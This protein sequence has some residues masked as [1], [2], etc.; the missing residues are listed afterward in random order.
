MGTLQRFFLNVRCLQAFQILSKMSKEANVSNLFKISY[1]LADF[2]LMV[3]FACIFQL[4]T[5]QLCS[6]KPLHPGLSPAVFRGLHWSE[7]SEAAN[8]SCWRALLTDLKP[9]QRAMLY[10]AMQEVIALF[11]IWCITYL[12]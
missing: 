10:S 11:L 8:C 1:I 5:E 7:I 4:T 12:P 6:L 2:A 9:G 3:A